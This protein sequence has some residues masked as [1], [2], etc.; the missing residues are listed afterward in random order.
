MICAVL[1]AVCMRWNLYSNEF[2]S[3][4]LVTPGQSPAVPMPHKSLNS[5]GA[6]GTYRLPPPP[7]HFF[8]YHRSLDVVLCSFVV[9]VLTAY[10][11]GLGILL[12]VDG[13]CVM[14]VCLLL[15]VCLCLFVVL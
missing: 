2:D 5:T 8:L 6:S 14:C 12:A 1:Y 4:D 7:L 11:L 3:L 9:C 13:S 10:A 15:F